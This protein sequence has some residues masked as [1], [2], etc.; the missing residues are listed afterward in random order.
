MNSIVLIGRL[1]KN[2]ELRYTANTQTA[3]ATFNLAVQRDKD[4]AD[5]FR[6]V[7]YGKQGESASQYLIKGSQVG[8]AGRVQTGSYQDKDGVR[9]STFDVIASRVEFLAHP[10]GANAQT[11]GECTAPARTS[12]P[13]EYEGSGYHL[14]DGFYSMDDDED[15]PF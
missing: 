10:K 12:E 4:N 13:E 7:V 6:I 11:P 15:I 2:P 5:F 3:V 14:P 8:V 1:T 9:R